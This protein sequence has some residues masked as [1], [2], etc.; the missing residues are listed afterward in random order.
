MSSFIPELEMEAQTTRRVLD[1]IPGDKLAWKPHDKSMSLGELAWHI[2]GANGLLSQVVLLD[3]FDPALAPRPT[4]PT[5]KEE[6]I[7]GFEQGVNK[8]KE[9]LSGMSNE[10]AMS[11][12]NITF[13]GK[14]ALSIP[15]IAFIRSIMMNHIYHHRGQL[16]VY[17][18]LLEI[19]VPS[20][21]GP[22]ADVN[23]FA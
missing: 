1:A 16:S 11:T 23:P 22:S 10:A 21:Y 6:M 20:I 13:G 5:T 2:A 8:A 9:V 19:P 15:K 14:P 12:L 17:L 18:R 7:A 3:T 4:P